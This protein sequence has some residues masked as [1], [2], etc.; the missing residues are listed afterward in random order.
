MGQASSARVGLREALQG[1]LAARASDAQAWPVERV[2]AVAEAAV[3][4]TTLTRLYTRMKDQPAAVDLD[5]LWRE[6]GVRNLAAGGLRL[7]D[8]APLAAVRRAI[9]T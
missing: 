5:T 3:D 4:Q 1:V 9:A 7:D 6:L 2:F 8:D